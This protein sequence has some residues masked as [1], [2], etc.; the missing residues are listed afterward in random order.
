MEQ[1]CSNEDRVFYIRLTYHIF[2]GNAI[3]VIKFRTISSTLSYLFIPQIAIF[4]RKT[5]NRCSKIKRKVNQFC[6]TDGNC[7][8]R[9]RYA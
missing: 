5:I 4:G 8:L 2:R 7:L 3:A 6:L 1:Y 9:V